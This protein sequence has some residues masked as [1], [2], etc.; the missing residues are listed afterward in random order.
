MPAIS[1]DSPLFKNIE[2][3]ALKEII[4]LYTQSK[5][6]IFIAIDKIESYDED[7]VK[8]VE[9]NQVIK[10]SEDKTLFTKNWKKT[11]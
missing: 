8:I 3:Y 2:D 10:L 4:K 1:H 11:D 9:K 7:T 5:K 6:Q